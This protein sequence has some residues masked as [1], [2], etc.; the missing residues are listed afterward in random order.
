MRVSK[1]QITLLAAAI[2]ALFAVSAHAN[3]HP[4]TEQVQ[5]VHVVE[6]EATPV[7]VADFAQ[8]AVV[9]DVAVAVSSLPTPTTVPSAAATEPT[10]ATNVIDVRSAVS[11]RW[12]Q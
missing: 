6:Q 7:A 1:N 8:K 2:C 4:P 5:V 9:Q 11:A 3:V 12:R 10:I